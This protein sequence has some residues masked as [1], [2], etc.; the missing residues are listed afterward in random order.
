MKKAGA[1]GNDP[2]TQLSSYFHLSWSTNRVANSSATIRDV[3]KLAELSVASVSRVLNGHGNVHADTRKRVLKAMDT[4][5]YVPNAAARSLSTAR[6]HAIGIVLPDLHGE[7]F[8]E[9]VRGMDMAASDA[10]YMMLLS[11][12][13]A[14]RERAIQALSAMRGRID[15]AIVMAPQLSPEDLRRALPAGSPAVLVNSPEEDG[16]HHNLRIDNRGGVTLMVRHLLASGRKRIVHLAGVAENLDAV[17]RK[18]AFCDTMKA[19]APELPV[20]VLDGD[21]TDT[22]AELLVQQ[23]LASGEEFDAIFAANDMMAL[24]A[25]K[26]LRT[27][28]ISVPGQVAVAGFDDIPLASF[29]DLTTMRIEISDFGKRA[30]ERLVAE[31]SNDA[32]P[33]TLERVTP[34]LITRATTA[35][36]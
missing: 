28:G 20:R 25:L 26:V 21:F 32:P 23:L 22:G 13:H 14:D 31:L 9:L 27:I 12:M 34:T 36:G 6:S 5:G 7:F 15:G 3:A 19:L 18:Q 1:C 8:S 29:L 2:D 35:S 16:Q 30:V 17:E 10:N 33:A 11:T 24:G 4:L